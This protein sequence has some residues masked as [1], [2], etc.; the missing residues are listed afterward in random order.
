[1]TATNATQ[2]EHDTDVSDTNEK[3]EEGTVSWLRPAFATGLLTLHFLAGGVMISFFYLNWLGLTPALLDFVDPWQTAFQLIVGLGVLLFN[4]IGM[5][6]FYL[7]FLQYQ[8]LFYDYFGI[9][10]NWLPD[11]ED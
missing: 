6:I 7:I 9:S 3:S 10:P 8:G 1:M 11:P 5:V 2:N 4:F